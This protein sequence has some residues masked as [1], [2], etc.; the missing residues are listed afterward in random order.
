MAILV[1]IVAETDS[2][3]GIDTCIDIYLFYFTL[4]FNLQITM[5]HSGH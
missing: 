2:K 1:V 5:K 4:Y 3:Y